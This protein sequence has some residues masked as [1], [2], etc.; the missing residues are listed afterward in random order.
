MTSLGFETY[1]RPRFLATL[2]VALLGAILTTVT[3]IIDL[4]FV[5]VVSSK[6]ND[7]AGGIL[8]LSRGNAVSPICPHRAHA[9]HA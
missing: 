3:F 8:H 5:S 9:R 2:G 7:E 1:S 6:I 4:A